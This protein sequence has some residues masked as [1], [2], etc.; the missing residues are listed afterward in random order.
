MAFQNF[1]LFLRI[2]DGIS[3]ILNK[4]TA[5]NVIDIK[6]SKFNT[7]FLKCKMPSSIYCHSK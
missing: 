7:W 6:F 1:L 4:K 2:P 5:F 3:A